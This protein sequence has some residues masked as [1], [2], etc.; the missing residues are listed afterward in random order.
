MA[1]NLD[2]VWY[3]L[4]P[5]DILAYQS[6]YGWDGKVHTDIRKIRMGTVVAIDI[7]EMA[8]AV[9][10]VELGKFDCYGAKN[11][12]KKAL[13]VEWLIE[14]MNTHCIVGLWS[15]VPPVSE[16]KRAIREFRQADLEERTGDPE[17]GSTPG[18]P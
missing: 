16:L 15:Y 5:G 11:P 9:G 18:I 4:K 3:E 1:K 6:R 13:E 7:F 14:W 10:V 8:M 2:D 12:G 17:A